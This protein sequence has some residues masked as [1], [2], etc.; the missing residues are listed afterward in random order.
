MLTIL[1]ACTG[2]G[3]IDD[4]AKEDTDSGTTDTDTGTTDGVS[5]V[6]VSA[7]G[8]CQI[9]TDDQGVWYL[10]ATVT[11][12]QGTDTLGIGTVEEWQRDP[13]EGGDP[14]GTHS[15]V[16]TDD[17]TCVASWEDNTGVG[18]CD[19]AGQLWMRVYAVDEDDHL[20]APFDFQTPE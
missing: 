2:E 13:A 14:V 7:T 16:C 17:G 19:L 11:D 15:T 4:S 1:L 8:Y 20:S 12:P 10:E 9:N 3:Q 18:G 5:P 6:V